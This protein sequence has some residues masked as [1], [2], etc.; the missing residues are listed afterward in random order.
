MQL[1]AHNQPA[2]LTAMS[3][4]S[5]TSSTQL[6][7]YGEGKRESAGGGGGREEVRDPDTHTTSHSPHPYKGCHN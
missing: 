1:W 6:G 7:Q 3:A 2:V 4:G 5:C